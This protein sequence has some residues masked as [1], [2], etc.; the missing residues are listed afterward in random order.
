MKKTYVEPVIE[1]VEVVT[2]VITSDMM[3]EDLMDGLVGITSYAGF[4][5]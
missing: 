5:Q 4:E 2:E 3:G 1:V